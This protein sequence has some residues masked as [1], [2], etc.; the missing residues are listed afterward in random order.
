MKLEK[1]TREQLIERG[2]AW[3]S[4]CQILVSVLVLVTFLL[5]VGE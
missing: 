1:Y 2:D 3:R 5:I 4:A